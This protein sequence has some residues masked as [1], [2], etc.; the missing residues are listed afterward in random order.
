MMEHSH[1]SQTPRK[2]PLND[3]ERLTQFEQVMLPH[4]A[5]AYNLARWLTRREEDAS[6]VTQEAMVRAFTFFKGYHGGDARSWLLTIVR[7]TCYTWLRKNRSHEFSTSFDLDLHDTK[8][9]EASPEQAAAQSASRELLRK[10][11]EEIPLEFREI[12]VLRE[13]EGLSYKEICGVTSRLA[14]ART[15]LQKILQPHQ[16]DEETKHDL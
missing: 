7:N 3:S 16:H 14:R 6:D 9:P 12:L 11:F 13:L 15:R 4:M 1:D 5:A 2:G 10:A 8:D